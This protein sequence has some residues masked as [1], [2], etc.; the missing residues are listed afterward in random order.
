MGQTSGHPGKIGRWLRRLSPMAR[1]AWY[2]LPGILPKISEERGLDIQAI[3]VF[4][5]ALI[6]NQNS[7][8]ALASLRAMRAPVH[9]VWQFENWLLSDQYSK[10]RDHYGLDQRVIIPDSVK[11]LPSIVGGFKPV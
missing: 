9:M 6:L 10:I 2:D 11:R 4:R 5:L 1:S 7:Y 8:Q 3:L